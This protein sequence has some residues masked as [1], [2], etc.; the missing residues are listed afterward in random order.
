MIFIDMGRYSYTKALD[1]LR[2]WAESEGFKD[3]SLNYT[4]VSLIN[5]KDKTLNVPDIIRIEKNHT[6]ETRV[7]LFL[8][9]LGHHELRRNWDRYRELFPILT[10]AEEFEL[11]HPKDYS[12]R[13]RIGYIASEIEEEF[14]AWNEGLRL[15][16]ELGIRIDMDKWLKLKYKSVMSYIRYYGSKKN[17]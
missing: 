2:E 14:M 16:N 7:Y 1:R 15:G 12:H 17:F 9:E 13:R 5:W 3:I 10:E 6:K 11:I 4:D 8:H